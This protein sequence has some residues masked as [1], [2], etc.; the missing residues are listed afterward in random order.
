MVRGSFMNMIHTNI[1]RTLVVASVL[2]AVIGVLSSNAHAQAAAAPAPAV[3]AKPAPK[4]EGSAGL[5][6]TLTQGNSDTIMFNARIQAL[7]KWDKNELNLAADATYGEANSVKNNDSFRF[8]AQY[9][10]LFTEQLYGYILTDYLHDDIADV[11]YRVNVGPGLGYYFI[12]NERTVLSAEAGPT[13]VFEDVGGQYKSYLTARVGEKFQ[14]K[15]SDRA[16]IWQKAEFL[17]QID[18]FNNYLFNFE[19]GIETDITKSVKLEFYVVDNYDNE[20][21]TGRKKNDIK[22]VAGVKYKF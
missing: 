15:L 1:K 22:F 4:W 18:D 17:P 21:A 11:S 8:S 10:R 16:R 6:V 19:I 12:K 20:P 7:R 14:Y 3:A 5:G 9:N 13:V 2:A